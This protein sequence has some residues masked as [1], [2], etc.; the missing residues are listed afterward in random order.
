MMSERA[1]L[2]TTSWQ[3]LTSCAGW[4]PIEFRLRVPDSSSD[5]IDVEAAFNVKGDGTISGVVRGVGAEIETEAALKARVTLAKMFFFFFFWSS[6]L[7]AQELLLSSSFELRTSAMN[8]QAA[9]E[10]LMTRDSIA[11]DEEA[12]FLAEAVETSNKQLLGII[13]NSA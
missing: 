8:V 11:G 2:Q 10:L 7:S 12:A 6:H 13:S 4:H 5:Y 3:Q 9:A 1:T